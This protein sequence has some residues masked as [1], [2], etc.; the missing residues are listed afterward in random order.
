LPEGHPPVAGDGTE[1]AR[2]QRLQQEAAELEALLAQSPDDP[3]LMVNLANLYYDA[4][5]WANARVWY[6]RALQTG[7]PDPD[8]ITDLAVVYRNLEQP[9][10]ALETLDRAIELAP[11][12][13][14]AVYNRVVIL[15]FDLHRHDE[16]V[17]SLERLKEI[18]AANP[19]VP[20]L[21]RLEQQVTGS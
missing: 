7:E 15:H 5:Q 3:R 12:H 18:A 4:A 8:V 17:S 13:W 1:I 19:D 21:S 20:D 14:Q 10:T 2:R 16:A 6:E 9:E 11:E